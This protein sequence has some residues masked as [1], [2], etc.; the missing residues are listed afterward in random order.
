MEAPVSLT[1]EMLL[2]VARNEMPTTVT[3][4]VVAKV[5]YSTATSPLA[6]PDARKSNLQ[7]LEGTAVE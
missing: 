4:G 3:P 6:L 5:D 7:P 1:S 2:Y